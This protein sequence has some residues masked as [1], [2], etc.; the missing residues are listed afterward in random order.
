M[1][2]N[3]E[4]FYV[5]GGITV[6]VERVM[7]LVVSAL[8][9]G[10]NY[11][12]YII[13][14]RNPIDESKIPEGEYHPMERCVWGGGYLKICDKEEYFNEEPDEQAKHLKTWLL[15]EDAL[16]KGLELMVTK[17]YIGHFAD[18]VQEKGDA[19]TADIFL[20]LCLF[21]EVVYG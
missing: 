19:N 11:W 6:T 8:E 17:E 7:D 10:S 12:Y 2:R 21:G 9:G 16:K 15:N 18:F 14:S 20:Q 1:S 4:T 5:V 13:E 3:K